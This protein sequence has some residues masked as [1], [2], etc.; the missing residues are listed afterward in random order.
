MSD[1][2]STR[3]FPPHAI[4]IIGLAGR[5]PGAKNIDEFWQNISNGVES[6][7]TFSDAE[8]YLAGVPAALRSHPRFV[9][10]GAKLEDTELFDAAFFRSIGSFLNVLGRP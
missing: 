10:K 3:S 7:E 2:L 6:L 5:F 9:R 4:A 1:A 8:L